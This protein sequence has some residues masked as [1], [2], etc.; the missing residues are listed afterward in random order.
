MR[1]LVIFLLILLL[2]SCS[3]KE[4]KKISVSKGLPKKT[5]IEDIELKNWMKSLEEKPYK[6]GISKLKNPF[7]AP[8][9]LKSAMEK[10]EKKPLDLVGI[11]EKRGERI[12]L[13][14]DDTRKGYIARVGTKIGNIEILEIGKDYII[15]EEEGTNIYGEKEKNKRILYLK[16]ERTL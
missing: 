4:E 3:Y 2:I 12:A 15:I 14:Q 1:Y 9:I 8:E 7:I 16:K 11:L 13:L 10:K 6:I 5:E